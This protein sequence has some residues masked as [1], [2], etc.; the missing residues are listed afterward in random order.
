M[1]DRNYTKSE[2]A[3]IIAGI[4]A[5]VPLTEINKVLLDEQA[6]TGQSRR[7]LNPSSYDLVKKKYLPMTEHDIWEYIKSPKT[8]GEMKK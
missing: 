4:N 8:L 1:R 6:K 2:R 5:K 7:T 3:I